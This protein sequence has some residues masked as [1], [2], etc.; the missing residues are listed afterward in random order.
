[1]RRVGARRNPHR[2]SIPSDVSERL[3]VVAAFDLVYGNLSR[4][5]MKASL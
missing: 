2:T 5:L 1:M 3:G 4:D